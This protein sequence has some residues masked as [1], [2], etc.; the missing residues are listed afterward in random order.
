MA[1]LERIAVIE[2]GPAFLK[3]CRYCGTLWEETL[4]SIWIVT[5]DEA[6]VAFPDAPI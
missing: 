4:R 3:R 5:P 1:A 6:K 2:D